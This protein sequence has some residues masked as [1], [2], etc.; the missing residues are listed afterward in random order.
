MGIEFPE[1]YNSFV[2][3]NDPDKFIVPEAG[4]GGKKRKREPVPPAESGNPR[5]K[6]CEAMEVLKKGVLGEPLE[7]DDVTYNTLDNEDGVAV[8]SVTIG[9]LQQTF[10]GEPQSG[11]QA[12]E[13]SAA[14]VAMIALADE[15]AP[16]MAARI[17]WQLE[18][19]R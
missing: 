18:Q 4:S 5:A 7:K 14:D 8:S 1:V 16:H 11:I 2:D 12:A 13:F 9:F 6:L 3:P 17:E 15:I 19:K 10:F